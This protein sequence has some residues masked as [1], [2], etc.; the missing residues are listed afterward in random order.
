MSLVQ[1]GSAEVRVGSVEM[2]PAG[3]GW[4]GLGWNWLVSARTDAV[5][6]DLARLARLGWSRLTCVG[7]GCAFS[8]AKLGWKGL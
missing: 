8:S 7:L 6:T 2:V 3:L 5:G 4:A 1:L